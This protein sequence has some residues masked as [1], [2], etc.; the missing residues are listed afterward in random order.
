MVSLHIL[1][2]LTGL[3][4]AR[5]RPSLK[6]AD[7]HPRVKPRFV[8]NWLDFLFVNSGPSGAICR[9]WALKTTGA[10]GRACMKRNTHQNKKMHI[11]IDGNTAAGKNEARCGAVLQGNCPSNSWT[12]PK[13]KYF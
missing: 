5:R 12:H 1:S 8:S 2:L 13:P 11:F 6:I 3:Y 10:R 7:F 4:D 9:A